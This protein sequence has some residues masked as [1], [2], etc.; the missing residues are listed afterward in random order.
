LLA[1]GLHVGGEQ[2]QAALATVAGH[3]RTRNP[4][5]STDRIN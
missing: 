2:R 5:P 4:A 3:V 1:Q